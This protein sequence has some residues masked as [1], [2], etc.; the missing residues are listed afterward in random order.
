MAH[1]FCIVVPFVRKE[2]DVSSEN[3]YLEIINVVNMIKFIG[4]LF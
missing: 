4:K 3:H 2:Y 1:K